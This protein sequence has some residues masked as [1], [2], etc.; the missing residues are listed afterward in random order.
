M[1]SASAGAS[2]SFTVHYPADY[3][4]TELA[5]SD[6]QFEVVLKGIRRRVV[7]ALD[8][9]FAKDVG[10]FDTLEALRGRLRQ[11]L[12]R[13][14]AQE[15]ERRVRADLLRTLADR[16][17]F[18]VP[19]ALVEREIDRRVEEFLR[20]LIAQRVDPRRAGIDWEEFRRNQHD[21]A[22]ESV[23]SA[24]VLDEVARREELAVTAEDIDREV[25]QAAARTGKT[26]AAVRADLEKNGGVGRLT[27]GLRR[28]KAVDFLMARAT[29][30]EG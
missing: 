25:A 24:L 20:R 28:E 13:G 6:V 26:A 10:E 18:E 1:R 2:K 9:E 21:P 27:A 7:P 11:D 14:A 5:G 4:I 8:D 17:G 3:S 30:A 15:A 23:K 12:E 19:A 16:V 22:T 29:I